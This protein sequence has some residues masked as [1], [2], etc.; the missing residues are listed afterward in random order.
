MY[1]VRDY[2]FNN[3]MVMIISDGVISSKER[4]FALELA[5]KWGYNTDSIQKLIDMAMNR[6]L[7]IRMQQTQRKDKKFMI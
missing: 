7:V 2:A 1:D 4:L 6:R 3:V 5:K